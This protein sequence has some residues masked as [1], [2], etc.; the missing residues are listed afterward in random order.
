MELDAFDA[1]YLFDL[2]PDAPDS[3]TALT[4]WKLRQARRGTRVVTYRG[5]LDPPGCELISR[6]SLV[7]GELAVFVKR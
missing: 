1:L 2:Q 3:C 4:W 5:R 7:A 6:V